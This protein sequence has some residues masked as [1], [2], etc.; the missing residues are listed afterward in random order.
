MLA[1]IM[2]RRLCF[3]TILLC[4]LAIFNSV[5]INTKESSS[6][7]VCES[8]VKVSKDFCDKENSKKVDKY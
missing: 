4:G 1:M 8:E 7:D 6:P 3:F 2:I 5:F